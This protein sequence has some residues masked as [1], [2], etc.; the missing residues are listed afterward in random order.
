MAPGK[1]S[2]VLL[3]A[4]NDP[5]GYDEQADMP[6][7]VGMVE[8]VMAAFSIDRDRVLVSGHSAGGFTSGY[9]VRRRPDLFTAAVPVSGTIAVSGD[10]VKHV[11]FYVVSGKKDFNNK[12]ATQAVEQMRAAGMDVKVDDPPEWDHNSVGDAW[13]RIFTW[14]DGLIPADA[15]GS[16]QASRAQLDKKAWGKAATAAKKVADAKNATVHAKRRAARVLAEV[17]AAAEREL[18]A[19]READ[20]S[21]DTKKAIDLLAKARPSFEGAAA[22]GKIDEALKAYRAK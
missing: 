13:Q 20:E 18:A 14:F 17:D 8:E 12:Q 9:L 22:A 4:S 6:Q 10:D 19:A 5:K 21:G 3:P 15:L 16:L 7:I 1:G 2:F 11:P